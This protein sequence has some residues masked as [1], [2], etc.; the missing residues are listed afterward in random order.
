MASSGANG[1]SFGVV[2]VVV[3]VVPDAVVVGDDGVG[4]AFLF[5]RLPVTP[6]AITPCARSDVDALIETS[7]FTDQLK[8]STRPE[9][10]NL[11]AHAE[12]AQVVHPNET[13]MVA[14]GLKNEPPN[15]NSKP[16]A[17]NAGYIVKLMDAFITDPIAPSFDVSTPVK[18]G[19]VGECDF[20]LYN[21]ISP[22]FVIFSLPFGNVKPP[23]FAHVFLPYA[24]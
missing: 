17:V 11:E 14:P 23:A 6:V 22:P 24:Q 18:I 4:S 16:L 3:V 9:K 8:S 19:S 15:P 1:G 10:P 2:G 5:E 13:P 21:E 7:V 20:G 12:L